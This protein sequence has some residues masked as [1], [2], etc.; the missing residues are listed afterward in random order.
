L[1]LEGGMLRVEGVGVGVGVGDCPGQGEWERWAAKIDWRESGRKGGVEGW[2]GGGVE[3]WRG[4]GAAG[5]GAGREGSMGEQAVWGQTR[6]ESQG[7]EPG[8]GARAGP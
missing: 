2:R 8:A 3:G 4:G 6:I 5:K 7:R 1:D